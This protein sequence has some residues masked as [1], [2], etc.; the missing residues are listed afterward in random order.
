MELQQPRPPGHVPE[1]KRA[2]QGRRLQRR[3]AAGDRRHGHR[4]GEGL[5]PRHQLQ[6]LRQA[7]ALQRGHEA[8]AHP[9]RRDVGPA[10][11][12]GAGEPVQLRVDLE[13]D[14]GR[15]DVCEL[16]GGL[17]DVLRERHQEAA[18]GDREEEEEGAQQRQRRPEG[19]AAAE[20]PGEAGAHDPRV[21]RHR[22]RRHA[23]H[24][25]RHRHGPR[26][27]P[28]GQQLPVPLDHS[29]AFSGVL[30]FAPTRSSATCTC[31]GAPQRK[32]GKADR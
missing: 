21:P 7:P 29:A 1:G 27:G 8:L 18:G 12:L 5:P 2:P 32:A 4:A 6:R 26:V 20:G 15:A 13:R 9:R 28:G 22:R 3:G 19:G 30:P 31:T 24:Q 11:L 10:R 25:R 23:P 16:R 17:A 14:R